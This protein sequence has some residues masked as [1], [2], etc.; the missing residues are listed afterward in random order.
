VPASYFGQDLTV[1]FTSATTFNILSSGNAVI[2]S[3]SFSATNGAEIAIAYPSSAPAGEVT[4][5][6]L[7][8]A[9][10]RPAIRSR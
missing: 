2:A 9:R 7:S 8:R 10:R 6:S 4:T 3:G 1:K 5:M